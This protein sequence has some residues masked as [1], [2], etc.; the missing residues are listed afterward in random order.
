MYFMINF[1]LL[2]TIIISIII[3]S[4][5]SCDRIDEL[6]D[7]KVDGSEV[8]DI[9][10]QM[11]EDVHKYVNEHRTSNGKEKLS[12]NSYMSDEAR[13]HSSNMA[14]NIVPFGH[15]GFSERTSRIW[16]NVGNGGV[17]ENVAFNSTGAQQVLEQWKNSSGHNINML[18]NYT[19]SGIG[20][21]QKGNV[22]YFTQ[23]FLNR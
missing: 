6:S 10:T 21:A 1:A 2:K 14:N 5:S 16:T 9:I 18:G 15:D 4:I 17:A 20:I 13:Q 22:F 7:P 8:P 23:I 12:I 11:E 19:L 3:L